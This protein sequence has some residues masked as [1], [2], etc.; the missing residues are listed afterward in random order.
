MDPIQNAT[1]QAALQAV[2]SQ[3]PQP[4]SADQ[5]DFEA[6]MQNGEQSASTNPH[7]TNSTNDATQ[8]Q[9]VASAEQPKTIGDAILDGIQNAKETYDM[10]AEKVSTQLEATGD[11]H[12]SVQDAMKLQYELI[13]MN[14]QQE[15][16]TKV[17]DKSS[18]GV[19]T[20]FKNQ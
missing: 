16:T 18:Q 11:Q 13:Q 6:A 3:T 8:T 19:Q 5:A 17:A 20:L 2:E 1:Q 15:M 12:M 9:E 14:L 4:Q 7:E 10:H